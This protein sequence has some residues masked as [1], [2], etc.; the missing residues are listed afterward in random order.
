ML[1]LAVSASS[2]KVF[3]MIDS[4]GNCEPVLKQTLEHLDTYA[5][6][7]L[8]TLVIAEKRIERSFY[9]PWEKAFCKANADLDE[10][11]KQKRGEPN[12]IDKVS[13][14]TRM[15]LQVKIVSATVTVTVTA[16]LC[17]KHMT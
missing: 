15:H 9:D 16:L 11:E 4:K 13:K 14:D 2:I 17:V 3:V 12:A 10:I 7:G 5:K 8:R 1:A 6:E